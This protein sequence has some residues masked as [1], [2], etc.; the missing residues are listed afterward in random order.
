MFGLAWQWT[1]SAYAPYPG[2]RPAAGAVG[3]YNGKFMVNQYV[4]R[5]SS[6][7]TPAGYSRPSYRNFSRRAPAGNLR[8]FVWRV[9]WRKHQRKR[10]S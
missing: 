9:I 10:S 8:V 7:A 2:F 1:S 6:I 3:E 4:L 5:G